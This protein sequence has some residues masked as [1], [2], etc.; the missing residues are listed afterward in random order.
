[1]LKYSIPVSLLSDFRISRISDRFGT[2]G[3]GA[4]VKLMLHM[5]AQPDC[6]I[7]MLSDVERELAG[8]CGVSH[9][10]MSDIISY[11][12]KLGLFRLK[13]ADASFYLS[14][15]IFENPT[16]KKDENEQPL[17]K[18]AQNPEKE[19]ETGQ[20]L[21]SEGCAEIL[22]AAE[23]KEKKKQKKKE[24]INNNIKLNN[25]P[26]GESK[27]VYLTAAEYEKLV[28]KFGA[29]KTQQWI[30]KLESYIHVFPDKAKKYSSHYHVILTWARN[31]AEKGAA[32]S[33]QSSGYSNIRSLN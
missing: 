12:I 23:K 7:E 5:A 18:V 8:Y 4:V 28:V 1:M 15:T 33:Q 20:N 9:G 10:L 16:S 30:E 13:D 19:S 14:C 2:K 25:L 6:R 17:L 27:V 31:E 22:P 21:I 3:F 11:G 29:A 24:D 32:F 26:Y